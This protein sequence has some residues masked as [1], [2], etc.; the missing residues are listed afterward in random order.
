MREHITKRIPQL[1]IVCMRCNFWSNQQVKQQM[2]FLL[3]AT[4]KPITRRSMS[5]KW[6]PHIGH[7][8]IGRFTPSLP[9][10]LAE[11]ENMASR[12]NIL[13]WMWKKTWRFS[14]MQLRIGWL[15]L[16]KC[17]SH[18]WS[19]WRNQIASPREPLFSNPSLLSGN[20][21]FLSMPFQ[22]GQ[23]TST[24]NKHIRNQLSC[25]GFAQGHGN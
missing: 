19:A 17:N 13:V 22:D 21:L 6:A 9:L 1:L 5:Y 15:P 14:F 8:D 11:D 20:N 16:F 7:N 25:V 23:L 10:T 12:L 4:W 3:L 18:L 24:N 2:W